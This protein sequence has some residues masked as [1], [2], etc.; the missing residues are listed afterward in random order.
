VNE[1]CIFC[2]IISGKIKSKE[3]YKDNFIYAFNDIRPQAPFHVIVIPKK[4][5]DW[6]DVTNIDNNL[7]GSIQ[8]VAL[9]IIKQFC[10][11]K[12]GF[13]LVSNC[14]K[15]ACQSVFH[16]HYHII[17]GRLFNWPPG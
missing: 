5:I 6:V 10:D 8:I 7:L 12:E 13:R 1:K 14:G 11:I 3:V 17:S 15:N 16:I 2:N 4:H 9:K